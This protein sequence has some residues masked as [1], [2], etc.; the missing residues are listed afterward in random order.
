MCLLCITW[1]S[2]LAIL[3]IIYFAFIAYLTVYLLICVGFESLA[4]KPWVRK[5]YW[6]EDFVFYSKQ[7]AKAVDP[8]AVIRRVSD[9]SQSWSTSGVRLRKSWRC[10]RQIVLSSIVE[11]KVPDGNTHMQPAARHEGADYGTVLYSRLVNIVSNA[12][13]S[14]WK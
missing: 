11:H 8:K 9:I 10:Y 6:V 14:A 4:E 2:A 12:S 7:S 3:G 5:H 1:T 13:P